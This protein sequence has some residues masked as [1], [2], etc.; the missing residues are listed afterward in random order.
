MVLT[1]GNPTRLWSVATGRPIGRPFPSST[2]GQKAIFAPDGRTILRA[3]FGR[4]VGVWPVPAPVAGDPERVGLWAQTITGM[5]LDEHDVANMLD[6]TAW[7]KGEQ[8]L[9]LL[10][11]PPD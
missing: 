9:Q 4:E 2:S 11:G 10:G 3:V 7:R 1:G 6:E 8:R 5:A